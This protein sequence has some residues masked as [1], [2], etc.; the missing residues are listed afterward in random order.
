MLKTFIALII[1]LSLPRAFAESFSMRSCMLL[2]IT[3]TAGNSLGY[4]VFEGLEE[5]IKDRGWCDYKPSSEV[6]GIFSKYR[7][8]LP[9]YLKDENV[10]K[11]VAERLK[12]GT[13]IRVNL[14]YEIDKV[15]VELTVIG[16][17]GSDVYMSEKTLLT[18]MSPDL[19]ITTVNNWLDLYE[20]TIPYDGKVLGVLGDQITFSLPSSK[21]V[22]IGQ[23]LS[24]KRFV[25]KK[26]HPLLKKIVEWDSILLAKAKAFNISKGQGLATIKVYTSS[27]K[28]VTGDWV[29]FEAP[30]RESS[31]TDEKIKELEEN[32]YGKL[33]ELTLAVGLSSQNVSTSSTNGSL[34]FGG[35]LYGIHAEAEAWITRNYFAIGEFSRNLGSLS[36]ESGSAES[37]SPAQNSGTLKI[38]GGYKYLPL[39]FFY[40]PQVNLY[41]GWANYSYE[42]DKTTDDGI[43]T[44][45]FTGILVGAGGSVPVKRELRIFG[46]GEII[47]FGEFDDESNIYGNQKSVSSLNLKIGMHY[48]YR[49]NIK[50]M[51]M[52]NAINNSAKTNGSNSEVTYR[53]TAL[54]FGGVFSF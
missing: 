15:Q 4:K 13:I 39:G 22:I 14:E 3:D 8:R 46:S 26:Q 35:L 41:A 47:P 29:R 1:T 38:G 32:S 12:V 27:K 34:K 20:A 17:N 52:F 21:R 51:G 53:D 9:E 36:N 33:G 49:P 23:D 44:N 7:E 40:G 16:E 30:T 31:I 25:N 28:V 45:S 54:K 11:T 43:G 18:E 50:I 6:I 2:P 42:M 5:D 24:I 48:Y 37:D 19:I 10:L